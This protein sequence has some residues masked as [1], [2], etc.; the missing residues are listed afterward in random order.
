MER[1]IRE[2]SGGIVLNHTGCTIGDKHLNGVFR[3]RS[4]EGEK[5]NNAPN[6]LAYVRK[7]SRDLSWIFDIN[8]TIMLNAKKN[9]SVENKHLGEANDLDE[10]LSSMCCL[11]E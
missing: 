7:T 8:Y 10:K 3:R 4:L 11:G 6:P 9:M 2:E 5:T 1:K